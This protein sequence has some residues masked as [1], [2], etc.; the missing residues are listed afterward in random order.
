MFLIKS[1]LKTQVEISMPQISSLLMWIAHK[2]NIT[3][4]LL[5][6]AFILN[7]QVMLPFKPRYHGKVNGE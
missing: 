3:C 1:A 4:L 2:Y 5:F 6:T 7:A